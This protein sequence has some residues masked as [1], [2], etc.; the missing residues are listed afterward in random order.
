MVMDPDLADLS[1]QLIEA[2]QRTRP[3]NLLSTLILS[4][5]AFLFSV[6]CCYFALFSVSFRHGLVSSAA[7][8][9]QME[10]DC[11]K[12]IAIRYSC[13]KSHF[14]PTRLQESRETRWAS[15][16]MYT[17]EAQYR[18]SALSDGL[19]R[20]DEYALFSES[21]YAQSVS[22]YHSMTLSTFSTRLGRRNGT[23][24]L[25]SPENVN[26]YP[27]PGDLVSWIWP[28]AEQSAKSKSVVQC[29]IGSLTRFSGVETIKRAI[30]SAGRPFPVSFRMPNTRFWVPQ[31]NA[32]SPCPFAGSQNCTRHSFPP[33]SSILGLDGRGEFELGEYLSMAIVGFNDNFIARLND[34]TWLKGG[35]VLRSGFSYNEH[36]SEYFFSSIVDEQEDRLCPD[37]ANFALWR[38]E[39]APLICLDSKFCDTSE[40]YFYRFGEDFVNARTR[41]ILTLD[42]PA[43]YFI[44]VFRPKNLTRNFAICGYSFIP[45]AAV[46]KIMANS[47]GSFAFDAVDVAVRFTE[48]SFPDVKS[49]ADYSALKASIFR[50]TPLSIR[51]PFEDPTDL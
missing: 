21:L 8:H 15:S 35:F 48:S 40:T 25:G 19:L 31:S 33:P 41:E 27:Q 4:I 23:I 18:Y 3:H 28:F 29:S 13:P 37:I 14:F 50:F 44:H 22:S 11:L 5:V 12:P 32:S 47:Y 10:T 49:S 6:G 2:E 26:L 42:I 45:Y 39:S 20:S 7:Q 30:S 38:N 51:F 17:L 43:E 16:I 9:A 24:I 46:E 34:G 1:E 36:S